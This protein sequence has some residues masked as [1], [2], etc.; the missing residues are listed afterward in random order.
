MTSIT[1][2]DSELPQ[3]YSGIGFSGQLSSH[4]YL[5]SNEALDEYYFRFKRQILQYQSCTMG[6]F[7][8]I[9]ST[10]KPS[11]VA[12]VRESIYCATAAWSLAQAYR[13]VDDDGGRAHELGQACVKCMRGILFC[14]LR[15]ADR[16]ELFKQSQSASTALHSVFDMVTG[17]AIYSDAEYNHLQI[18]AVALYLI[19]LSQMTTSGLEIVYT[20]DEVNFIQNLVFYV[21]RAYRTPD[22]GMWERGSK[23]NNGITE[24]HASSIGMAKA[25]LEAVNGCNLFGEQGAAWSVIF[26]DIDAHNR[27]RTIFESILP[28]ESCSKNTDGALLPTLGWPAFAIHENPIKHRAMNKMVRHLKGRYGFKRF[29]R[30]GYK[31][32]VEDKKRKHYEVAEVKNFDGI[33]SEWPLFFIY[34]IIDCIFRGDKEGKQEYWDMLDRV[35][36]HSH[37]GQLVPMCYYVPWDVVE[38][39]RKKPGSQDK[40]PSPEGSTGGIFMWGQALYFIAQLLNDELLLVNQL[41]VIRRNLPA[42]E[43]PKFSTRYSKFQGTAPD[44]VI[45]VVLIAE[46]VRLQQL[47]ATYGIQTQTPHQVEPIQIWSPKELTKAYSHLGVNNKLGL[48]GR[49]SR[50]FGVLS[51]SKIYRACSQTIVCYPLLFELSDFYLAQDISLVMDDCKNDLRFLSKCW[52]LHGR[53]TWCMIIRENAIKGQNFGNFLGLLS[54]FKK[55]I[56]DGIHIRLG[57]LQSFLTTG[58][59]EHLDFL[60]S[61]PD[62]EIFQAFEEKVAITSFQSLTEIPKITEK[63]DDFQLDEK[64]LEHMSTGD[65]LQ[66]YK[67]VNGITNQATILQVLLKREGPQFRLDGQQ[68]ASRIDVIINKAGVRKKWSLVRLLSALLGKGVDSLAPSITSVLVRG[69]QVTL[70]VFKEEE[71]ILDKPVAP[72]ELIEILYRQCRPYDI[73]QAVLQQEIILAIGK[74]IV[75]DPRLFDGILKI[76]IGWILQAMVVEME[77]MEGH[78]VDI[79]S[80]S[81]H[82]VKEML[83]KVLTLNTVEADRRSPFQK[84]QLDGALNRVPKDFYCRIWKILE[85]TPGG[86]KVAGLYLPQQPTLSD[87]T[88]NELNFS[89]LVEQMLC[90]LGDPVNRQGIVE[91]VM[92][93]STILER[94]PELTFDKSVMLD[95]LLMEAYTEFK[96]DNNME[97]CTDED[98]LRRFFNMPP[99]VRNGTTAYL[100]RAVMRH[101]LT[102]DFHSVA[103]DMCC[104]T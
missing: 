21:E 101:L 7:P 80:L 87:M 93:V 75:L 15:Q 14:W 83:F 64:A 4:L 59:V 89:L 9:G 67:R 62:P 44:L 63:E 43:R 47:L 48:S 96:K 54:Q 58:C 91:A 69:K 8:A 77:N 98:G 46:S 74:L 45:Q 100:S 10:E 40:V 57:K 53:P 79:H 17:D 12:F 70:G 51:T 18:D 20:T 73:R 88:I 6:L 61:I 22:F 78:Y 52:K 55:G 82:Q 56:V 39:E 35:L 5:N 33:E 94:N 30:D 49:P 37:D 81:P 26:V 76:R 38:L 90:R 60:N 103:E 84:R 25:A 104:V 3:S 29:V 13:R 34:M 2:E 23:Y 72:S 92:V 41:D 66:E 19:A 31:T 85:R 32:V 102:G 97:N 28:R 11:R 42:L 65:I 36:F 16:V 1:S 24:L 86:I 71:V 27:N 68:V 99:N 50:P 95:T